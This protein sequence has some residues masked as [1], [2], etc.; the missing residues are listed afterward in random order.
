MNLLF[1]LDERVVLRDTLQ[2]ELLHQV[3][4]EGFPEVLLL[5][6]FDRHRERGGVEQNLPVPGHEID[7]LTDHGLKLGRQELVRFVHGEHRGLVEL[8]HAFGG[9]IDE[10]P[11]GGDDDVHGLVQTHDVILQRRAARGDH[12][13][14]AEVL[15]ELFGNLRRLERQLARGNQQHG[16]DHVLGHVRLL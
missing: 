6:R 12:H 13:L 4:H 5:E 8:G 1:L 2:S 14:D 9:E 7:E 15:A 11:G 16:L 10:S 3:D